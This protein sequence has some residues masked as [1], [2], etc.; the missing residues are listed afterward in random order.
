M[1][2]YLALTVLKIFSDATF[3]TGDHE[4]T[5]QIE[6]NDITMKTKPILTRFGGN[7]GRLRFDEQS[8]FNTL[9]GFKP[10]GISNVPIQLM[11]IVRVYKLVEKTLY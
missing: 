8:L 6:Y 3:T 11:V 1:K 9:L 4:G 5:P 7:F 10:F 2:C